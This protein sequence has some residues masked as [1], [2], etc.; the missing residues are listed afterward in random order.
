M[1]KL[2]NAVD[3]VTKTVNFIRAQASNHRQLVALLEERDNE[4][5]DIRYHTAVRWHSLGKV[6]KRF[7]N[8]KAEMEK[9]CEIKS[10]NIPELSDV[11]GIANL[12]FAVNVTALMNELNT[13]LQGKGFFV[14]QM[15]NLIKAFMRK[16]Q[17]L[18]NQ[19]E[20]KIPT[21]I[22]TLKEVKPS[23]THLC[24]YSSMLGDLHSEFSRF[25]NLDLENIEDEMHLISSSFACNVDNALIDVQLELMDLQSDTVLV[26]HSKSA[27][28]LESYSSLKKGELSKHEKT[29][30]EDVG[31]FCIH[32]YM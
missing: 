31:S 19:L 12:A 28:L 25:R 27:S 23:A 29:C 3:V 16:L 5:V 15:H 7:W 30:S 17:F 14:H 10:K 22:Q 11:D 8:L 32:L 9:F 1:L 21:H 18:S 4:H 26:E 6:S 13:I 2:N 24:N 20:N